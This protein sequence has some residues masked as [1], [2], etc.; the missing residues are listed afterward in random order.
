MWISKTPKGNKSS[1]SRK[2]FEFY[3]L[4]GNQ[5]R[6]V[7]NE[8]ISLIIQYLLEQLIGLYL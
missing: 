8:I 7:I 2:C 5:M 4:G 6:T 3:C 1:R